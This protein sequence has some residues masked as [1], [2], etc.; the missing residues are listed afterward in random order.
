[1]ENSLRN[2]EPSDIRRW[3]GSSLVM[4]SKASMLVAHCCV[5]TKPHPY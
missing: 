3:L 2:L 4:L 1:M 5:R